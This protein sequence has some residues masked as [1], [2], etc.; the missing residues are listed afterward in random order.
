MSIKS[1]E[2]YIESLLQLF[3]KLRGRPTA[4]MY[5][6]C[7]QLKDHSKLFLGLYHYYD[8]VDCGNDIYV[9]DTSLVDHDDR[10]K[11]SFDIFL[12][13][14]NPGQGCLTEPLELCYTWYMI[15]QCYL[16]GSGV[17]K[18]I[19]EAITWLK[20]AAAMGVTD[21][22]DD[23]AWCYAYKDMN[24][25]AINVYETAF[26]SGCLWAAEFIFQ[27]YATKQKIK[28]IVKAYHWST[29]A[30]ELSSYSCS[31]LENILA[32]GQF[33]W[34]QQYHQYWPH[35][36]TKGTTKKILFG[37][38]TLTSCGITFADQVFVILLISKFRITSRFK[39]TNLLMKDIAISI[40][41]QLG[42]IWFL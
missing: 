30:R 1:R 15:G 41:K 20:K 21:A 37:N 19:N 22:Y 34:T 40:I 31:L 33:E 6:I 32:T 9:F 26:N 35:S 39:F 24:E 10:M 4:K 8:L 36:K 13:L 38:E 2:I 23:L 14:L 7:G 42:Q 11:Q 5:N 17:V 28:D 3:V 18:D 29:K 27:L 16:L 25:E 12:S